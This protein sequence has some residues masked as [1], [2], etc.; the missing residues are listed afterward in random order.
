MIDGAQL[1][2]EY[3]WRGMAPDPK[4]TVSEWSDQFRVLSTVGSAEPGPWRT[5]RTPYLKEIMDA[6]SPDSRVEE[7]V[8]MKGAQIGYS[9][10]IVNFIGYCIDV[11]SGP[12]LCVQPTVDLAKRFS[13]QRID[14]LIENCSALRKK[15][16]N[17]RERDSGN[18]QLSKLFPGGV[19]V[20]TGGNSAVGLRSIP[21]RFL[22]LDEIDAMDDDIAGEGSPIV[23]AKAR[24]RTFSRRKIVMGST[25]TVQNRSKI[26]HAFELTDKKFYFVPCPHCN[27]FQKIVWARIKWPEDDPGSAWLECE[28]CQKPI[29]EHNKDQ[30]LARGKWIATN[31]EHKDKKVTGFHI[32]SLY[33]P[34][35]WYSWGDAAKDF[36]E[37]KGSPE[38]LRGFVNTVL[39]ESWQDRGDA[40]EWRRLY[41]RRENYEM[42]KVPRGVGFLTC[43][44]DV[45]KDRIEAEIV[46]W[47]FGKT[48]WSI[49]YRIFYGD[50]ANPESGAWLELDALLNEQF[51]M[52]DGGQMVIRVMAVDSGFNTQAVYNWCRKY[53]I[54]R[55][56]ATKGSE[57]APILLSAP[58]SVDVTLKQGTK[59]RRGFKLWT[60]GVNIAKVELYSWL[61]QDKP[62]DGEAFPQAYCHFPEYGDEYFK[63]LTAEVLVTRR[64][65]GYSKHVWEKIRDRNE[66]LDCRVLA[67]AAAAAFGI[68]RFQE[69][70][71][72][73]LGCHKPQEVVTEKG[74][75]VLDQTPKPQVKPKVAQVRR[76]SNY[77]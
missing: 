9:E 51:E 60:V 72:D 40:P 18:T 11:T 8:V 68:D 6:L 56:M 62:I 25:P 61:R 35:G 42:G 17:S 48:S 1:H 3:F 64:V 31:P 16:I 27:H 65:R 75:V 50:T 67:R 41:E 14:P 32:S 2:R 77:I 58:S 15:I 24:T 66:A 29:R 22:V 43:G 44:V 12:I 28:E 19:L 59:L 36:L 69:K 57:S 37:A 33:S 7:V 5:A 13:K 26:E 54:S 39:G 23:L 30:M 34:Y 20:L 49:D 46:G 38:R 63:Q 55:V 71:W 70:H 74:E 52:Q 47:G 45:Q 21:V 4:L 53:P 10:A 73:Q 76:K